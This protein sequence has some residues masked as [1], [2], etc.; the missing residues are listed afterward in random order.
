MYEIGG[1]AALTI[2]TIYIKDP[3]SRADP[4]FPVGGRQHTILPNFPKKLHES[5]KTL[6][7]VGGG[8]T[9]LLCP[10]NLLL[11]LEK[12]MN[13]KTSEAIGDA[14]I[15]CTMPCPYSRPRNSISLYSNKNVG[16]SFDE[17]EFSLFHVVFGKMF[18][19]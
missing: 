8:G 13:M 4:G 5:E 2:L 3:R 10:L 1:G 12:C 14:C 17:S 9:F 18:A 16:A 11:F 15:L 19:K 7:H 6:V